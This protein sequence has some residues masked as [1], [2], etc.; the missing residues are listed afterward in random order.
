M[1]HREVSTIEI[2]FGGSTSPRVS[3]L[4]DQGASELHNAILDVTSNSPLVEQ[5]HVLKRHL[6][7][8]IPPMTA[9]VQKVVVQLK[10]KGHT[11]EQINDIHQKVATDML[12][13]SSIS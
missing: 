1:I 2:L 5:G 11:I 9:I 3:C 8:R 7:T 6:E 4:G 10:A 13:C 12:K